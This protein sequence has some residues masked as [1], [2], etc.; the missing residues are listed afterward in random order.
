MSMP[1]F[2]TLDVD[3]RQKVPKNSDF[4]FYQKNRFFVKAK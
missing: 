1:D 2:G 3:L 4:L